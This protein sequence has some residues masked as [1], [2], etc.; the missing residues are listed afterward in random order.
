M[1]WIAAKLVVAYVHNE[2]SSG[3]A[4][5]HQFVDHSVGEDG[6]AP[7]EESAIAARKG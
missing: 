5:H 7:N 3:D 1:R 2:Q 6:F 4:A